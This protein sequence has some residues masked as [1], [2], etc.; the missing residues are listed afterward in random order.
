LTLT[1]PQGRRCREATVLS[2]I[3]SRH[4]LDRSTA[5]SDRYST[6]SSTGGNSDGGRLS[7]PLINPVGAGGSA[8][9][10]LLYA[11]VICEGILLAEGALVEPSAVPALRAA[12]LK[13]EKGL[14]R[15]VSFCSQIERVPRM[16]ATV[17]LVTIHTLK[18]HG[19]A[20]VVIA[21]TAFEAELAS[22]LCEEAYSSFASAVQAKA[23][24][25]PGCSQ[26]CS[27]SL[28]SSAETG[29]AGSAPAGRIDWAR[30]RGRGQRQPATPIGASESSVPDAA[31]GEQLRELMWQHSR[32]ER[33]ARYRRVVSL[34]QATEEVASVMEETVDRLLAN[35]Q[36]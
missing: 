7:E 36:V 6:A 1:R 30:L 19:H 32:P 21:L 28:V 29:G 22:R 34:M 27:R 25:V 8:L 9:E 26:L 33:I 2:T 18:R 16:M 10:P 4:T 24:C 23:T 12:A 5:S 15:A 31:F 20:F 17:P 13:M 14:Q 11:A 35:S 3:M